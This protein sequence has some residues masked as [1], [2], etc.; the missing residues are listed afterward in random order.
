MAFT[1]DDSNQHIG[2]AEPAVLSQTV[3]ILE[4]VSFQSNKTKNIEF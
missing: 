4:C 3:F 2:D 1:K